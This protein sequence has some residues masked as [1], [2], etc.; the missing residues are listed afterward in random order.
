MRK[1]AAFVNRDEFSSAGS[2]TCN[3]CLSLVC[4]YQHME[5]AQV[6]AFTSLKWLAL[7]N[8][9]N[10]TCQLKSKLRIV[11]SS[12]QQ[13]QKYCPRTQQLQKNIPLSAVEFLLHTG[14]ESGIFLYAFV[15]L[16]A[17]D[18]EICMEGQHAKSVTSEHQENSGM[19]KCHLLVITKQ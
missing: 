2:P 3:H 7:T 15:T 6:T 19:K 18:K 8:K 13:S 10:F 16:K 1:N 14:F 17:K 9:I 12:C 11:N 4:F 5:I